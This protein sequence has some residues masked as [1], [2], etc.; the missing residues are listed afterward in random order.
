MDAATARNTPC[1]PDP[2]LREDLLVE[3]KRAISSHPNVFLSGGKLVEVVQE[4]TRAWLVPLNWTRVSALLWLNGPWQ[5]FLEEN[6]LKS[7]PW[8]QSA[9]L[10]EESWPEA[11]RIAGI[12]D[13]PVLRPDGT[14][15][16]TPGYDA[17]TG[18]WYAP[19][20]DVPPIP[21]QP[22]REETRAAVEELEQILNVFPIVSRAHRSSMLAS[23]LT[24]FARLA[25]QGPSPLFLLDA[26]GEGLGAVQSA[27]ILGWL[28]CGGPITRMEKSPS[29]RQFRK[30]LIRLKTPENGLVL[31][32]EL[33]ELRSASCLSTALLA[34]H[35]SDAPPQ[36]ERRSVT[37]FGRSS[38]AMLSRSTAEGILPIR[39]YD[40]ADHVRET[41]FDWPRSLEEWCAARRARFVHAALVLLRA[42]LCAGRPEQ[43]R[44]V[45][46]RFQ[47]WSE[48]IGGALVW[49]GFEDP[50]HARRA[51]AAAIGDEEADGLRILMR[52]LSRLCPTGTGLTTRY[53][54]DKCQTEVLWSP[55]LEALQNML[56]G[57]ALDAR[58]VG[59]L[60]R[61]NRGVS[62]DGL[63][64]HRAGQDQ[65]GYARWT[66][67]RSP[68]VEPQLPIPDRFFAQLG[69]EENLFREDVRTFHA[70]DPDAPIDRVGDYRTG[71]ERLDAEVAAALA[72]RNPATTAA[73][74]SAES[75]FAELETPGSADILSAL[76]PVTSVRP[77]TEIATPSR[78]GHSR[79]A[80]APSIPIANVVPGRTRTSG[81]PRADRMSAVPA[82]AQ[83]GP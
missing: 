14:L 20:I 44:P 34:W 11:R 69:P 79:S 18:L 59:N 12:T 48:L 51:L 27:D 80:P 75:E 50:L 17:Q 6:E 42:F 31:F 53:I 25:F 10:R 43:E 49:A 60:L 41:S 74:E 62:V 22:T 1:P 21:E 33:Q 77:C 9:I 4:R 73:P 47:A 52:A 83:A 3:A 5:Y 19:A 81:P 35:W 64:I 82:G 56:G 30:Q 45:W 29:E 68:L 54:V 13:V 55:V 36:R 37:W 57:R 8:L 67:E 39:F 46:V 16:T 2:D 70:D 26:P 32:E 78:D 61:A 66:V 24:P 23:L 7:P 63:F 58:H 65:S 28:L 76:L 38:N 72:E 71:P 15:L 40:T